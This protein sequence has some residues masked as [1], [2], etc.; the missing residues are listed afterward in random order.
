VHVTFTALPK[1]LDHEGFDT[2]AKGSDGFVLQ[3]YSLTQPARLAD[4]VSMVDPAAA[5]LHTELAAKVGVPFRIALPTH[6]WILAFDSAGKFI[7][8]STEDPSPRWPADARLR[9]VRADPRVLARIVRNIEADRPLLLYGILWTRFP[10]PGDHRNW[11]MRTLKAVMQGQEPLPDLQVAVTR[12]ETRVSEIWLINVGDADAA[13]PG[14]IVATWS[15]AALVAADAMVGFE[16][17]S[18]LDATVAFRPQ[19]QIHT[20]APGEKRLVGWIRL[21]TEAEVRAVLGK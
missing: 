1:W 15:S 9:T 13:I 7:A 10:A 2:L 5:L 12:P 3:I 4:A 11:K 19:S 8:S 17:V 14:N 20:L 18:S 21:D 16:R 6:G